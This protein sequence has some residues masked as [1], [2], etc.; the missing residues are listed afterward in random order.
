MPARLAPQLRP[1][2]KLRLVSMATQPIR[3][4]YQLHNHLTVAVHMLCGT[5]PAIRQD[6]QLYTEPPS[7]RRVLHTRQGWVHYHA[8]LG[9]PH[10]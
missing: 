7:Q 5:H 4:G 1:T 2:A 3:H 8:W 6:L 9:P 10:V